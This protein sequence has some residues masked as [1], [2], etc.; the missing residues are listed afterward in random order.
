M[1]YSGSK[2][3]D[4][5][6]DTQE[7]NESA[8]KTYPGWRFLYSPRWLGYYAMLAIFAV[9]CVLLSNWQFAR[10]DERR[11]ANR[12]L[13]QNYDQAPAPLAELFP[14]GR[15]F[16]D[17]AHKWRPVTMQGKYLGDPILVR[18][19]PGPQNSG[20]ETVQAF[21][22]DTGQIV[23]VDRGWINVQVADAGADAA[24]TRRTA[25]PE[26]P[27][28]VTAR[29]LPAEGKIPGREA[30]GRSVASINPGDL[31]SVAGITGS[32]VTSA[33][34]AQLISETPKDG[35]TPPEH[36][37]L[38]PKPE[39]DEGPHFSYAL[40]WLVF[41]L[42]AAT[43]IGYAARQEFRHFNRGSQR[44]KRAEAKA[45]ARAARNREKRGL[46]DAEEED[47]LLGD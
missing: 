22:T 36:G 9:S 5:A 44:V 15:A 24:E 13:E 2:T 34:Y 31:A 17:N 28:T 45:A 30:A 14:A 29:L 43:G 38:P 3:T 40:Q 18:N 20:S 21:Q 10:L 37:V 25:A 11:E 42:I 46:S 41:I 8:E 12:I 33:A 47:Q 6:S 16:N 39:E 1:T 35:A 26:Q 27:M 23:F 4:S 32:Q 7:I 19:R